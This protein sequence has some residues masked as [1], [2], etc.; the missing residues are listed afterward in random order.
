MTMLTRSSATEFV[1]THR[2]PLMLALIGIVMPLLGFGLIAEDV[3]T[4]QIFAWDITWLETLHRSATP[5]W[6]KFMLVMTNIGDVKI[7]SG[8]VAFGLLALWFNGKTRDMIFLITALF[9]AA[10]INI[11]LKLEFHRARP[12]LWNWLTP[13]N[14]FGFPSGHTMGSVA[15]ASALIVLAWN[16]RWRYAVLISGT[17]FAVLVSLSRVYL[18]VHYPSDVLAGWAVSITWVTLVTL[19]LRR[20]LFEP[21]LKV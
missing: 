5:I 20:E 18:G 13:E 16:T 6:D 3:L 1:T 15:V 14:G 2:N 17:V 9:G 8:L 19:T 11:V 12:H 21:T 10:A 4:K 7:L